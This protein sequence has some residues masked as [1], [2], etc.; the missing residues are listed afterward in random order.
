MMSSLVEES[1]SDSD[2]FDVPELKVVGLLRLM[3]SMETMPFVFNESPIAMP[4]KDSD[5]LVG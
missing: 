3:L 5:K 2:I 4:P 1:T